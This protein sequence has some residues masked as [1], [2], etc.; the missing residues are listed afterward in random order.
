MAKRW[1]TALPLLDEVGNDVLA[2]IVGRVGIGGVAAELVEQELAL[3]DVDAHGGERHVRLVGHAG[4][5]LRLF[6][7]GDDA[8]L[9]VDV[10]DAEAGR[11]H[12]RHLEAADGDVGA[13]IDVL[14]EH[15]LVVH[16]VD[17]VAGEHDDVVGAVAADDVDVLEDRVGG[18]GVPLVLRRALARRQDIEALVAFR[19]EEGPAAL[20]VADEAVGLVLGG[21]RDAPDAGVKGI[22]QGEIDDARLAAEEHGGLGALVGQLHQP[23]AATAG[24]HIGHRIRGPDVDSGSVRSSIFLPAQ[25]LA[26]IIALAVGKVPR[27]AN[28]ATMAAV[29]TLSESWV[30]LVMEREPCPHN[31]KRSRRPPARRCRPS[32]AI[33]RWGT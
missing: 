21:D 6:E 18:A 4:R 17:V 24:Q 3:E 13:R 25:G 27:Y 12:A 20:K 7:E 32:A 23:A 29:Q 16:L 30:A 8:V 31:Q 19:P 22:G 5:I 33:P 10:H 2:E 1:A 9:V 26:P 15:H 11:L 14:L 28:A